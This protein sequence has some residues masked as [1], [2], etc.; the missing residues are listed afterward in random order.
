MRSGKQR[1]PARP[2]RSERSEAGVMTQG[3]LGVPQDPLRLG[4]PSRHPWT[5][6]R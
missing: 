1:I 4:T 2:R 3:V 5:L 6:P